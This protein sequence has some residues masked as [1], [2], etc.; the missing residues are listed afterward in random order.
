MLPAPSTI[1]DS[2]S[3][4]S[5]HKLRTHSLPPLG[6]IA[7]LFACQQ[8][9]P[10]APRF[11]LEGP[12]CSQHQQ[13]L[14]AALA[15][16]PDR[17]LTSPSHVELPEATIGEVPSQAPLLE[18][19]ESSARFE[20]LPVAGNSP[21]ERAVNVAQAV[22]ELAEKAAPRDLNV[23]APRATDIQ[24]LRLYLHRI[25][26]KFRIRLLV[27]MPSGAPLPANSG[28]D[29][30]AKRLA[31]EILAQRDPAIRA[32]L[33][34]DAFAQFSRC[35][36]VS[37]ALADADS[38]RSE[39]RWP[40]LR[41]GL[42]RALPECRCSDLIAESLQSI[43]V[44]EQ[45]AGSATL[46]ALPIG[47]VRD[48]RCGA[49]M[50]LRSVGKLLEQ[51][52]RFDQEFSGGWQRDALAFE[53][54]L[55]EERLLNTFCNALPGETLAQ[56]SK[57]RATI[58]WKTSGG[59][60]CE[61]FQFEPLSPGAPMGTLRDVTSRGSVMRAFHFWQG[62]EELRVF[63]PLQPGA[64]SK[65]TDE[66]EWP[67]DQ[68]LKLTAVSGESLDFE[69]GRWFFSEAACKTAPASAA[70]EGCL[71]KPLATP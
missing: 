71:A 47:F 20:G 25:P 15:R 9:K 69:R 35:A 30:E 14:L 16:L 41:K 13:D 3:V 28:A 64:A 44:A 31:A 58:Y 50:P 49:S 66:R 22:R 46:A 32:R 18:I 61:A 51:M 38:V 8:A 39:Q 5:A 43:V 29:S 23:A 67:C 17:A 37:Q 4:V 19:D 65:P 7:L 45:R 70:M 1:R 42:E 55:T 26:T 34:R 53:K 60:A 56:L 52:E 63:G 68:N 40:T 24:T 48:E 10:P 33:S 54:V 36:G 6:V 11:E 2:S 12:A 57:S 21:A 27:R 59:E 62:A